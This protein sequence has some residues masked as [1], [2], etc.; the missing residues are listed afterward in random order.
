MLVF[1]VQQ[2]LGIA[3]AVAKIGTGATAKKSGIFRR[4]A[5]KALGAPRPDITRMKW[6]QKLLH[7]I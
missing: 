5:S 7:I 3:I 1:L 6:I 4:D 2:G